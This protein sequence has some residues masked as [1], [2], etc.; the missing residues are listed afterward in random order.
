LIHHLS[1]VS[2]GS[3]PVP[4]CVSIAVPNPILRANS[5]SM[6]MWSWSS[7]KRG[8]SVSVWDIGQVPIMNFDWLAFTPLWSPSPVLQYH[9]LLQLM[10]VSSDSVVGIVL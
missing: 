2:L 4:S 5:R 7:Y 10:G 3:L 9:S 8:V 1:S 6:A